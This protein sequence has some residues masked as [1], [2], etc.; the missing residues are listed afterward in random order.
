M[1]PSGRAAQQVRLNVVKSSQHFVLRLQHMTLYKRHLLCLTEEKVVGRPC[2]SRS[3]FV[4]RTLCGK[5]SGQHQTSPLHLKCLQRQSDEADKP[6]VGI[7]VRAVQ[8]KVAERVRRAA[9]AVAKDLPAISQVALKDPVTPD[10]QQR[11][12]SSHTSGTTSVQTAVSKA[13][14]T[15]A[16]LISMSVLCKSNTDCALD[17]SGA[18]GLHEVRSRALRDRDP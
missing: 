18:K 5:D 11:D 9:T 17:H 3:G 13:C 8:H 6:T 12:T 15:Y 7:F 2:R 4:S 16:Q 10:T 1:L 14:A